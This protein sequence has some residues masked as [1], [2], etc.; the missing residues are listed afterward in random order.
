MEEPNSNLQQAPL[1][2]DYPIPVINLTGHCEFDPKIGCKLGVLFCQKLRA[3]KSLAGPGR[4]DPD[5]Q[6]QRVRRHSQQVE[7]ISDK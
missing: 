3:A 4:G 1:A 2:T 6:S 7:T 5:G